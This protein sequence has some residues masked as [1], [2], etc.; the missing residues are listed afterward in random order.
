MRSKK[1]ENFLEIGFLLSIC[2]LKR[3]KIQDH[4]REQKELS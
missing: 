4:K 2:L 1:P 3:N